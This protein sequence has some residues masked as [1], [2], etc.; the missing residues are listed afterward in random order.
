M[1][2]AE[3]QLVLGL[4]PVAEKLI[5]T[6]GEAVNNEIDVETMTLA[7]IRTKL[8]ATASANWPDLEFKSSK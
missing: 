3:V 4:I 2:G 5:S 7:E 8:E 6:I 1:T